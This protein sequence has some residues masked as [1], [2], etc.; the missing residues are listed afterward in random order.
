M[1]K[2]FAIAAV[3][4]LAACGG[5]GTDETVEQ[6][7]TTIQGTDTVPTTTVVPTTDTMITTVTT[8]TVQGE[9]TDTTTGD[10]TP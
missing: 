3:A 1:K 6:D 5:D 4:L 9:A 10:T 8:D 2:F 7:T